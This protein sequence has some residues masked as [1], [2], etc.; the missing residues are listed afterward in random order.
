MRNSLRSSVSYLVVAACLMVPCALWAADSN[1]ATAVDPTS[2]AASAAPANSSASVG[3]GSAV[4]PTLVDL[5]VKKGILTTTEAS[6]LRNMSG[7]AGMQQLL[8]L[9]KAKGVVNDSEVT[10]LKNAAAETSEHEVFD[11]ESN[12]M[13]ASLITG[14]AAQAKAPEKPAGPVVIPAIAPLRVLPVDP[15]KK[16][17]LA[18]AITLGAVRVLPYGFV[19]AT[20]AYDTSSPRGD[21]FPPP[22]FL[23]ADTGPNSNPEFHS[24]GPRYSRGFQ[25]RMARHFEKRDRDRPNRGRLRRQ[26]QPG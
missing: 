20:M 23:N 6:S 13:S 21:D 5:L 9:L 4:N 12:P 25:V 22:G 16:D 17:G 18:P 1:A 26:L 10:E 24:E 15:A 19:K 3:A 7:S 2:A 11:T 8:M 14:Q